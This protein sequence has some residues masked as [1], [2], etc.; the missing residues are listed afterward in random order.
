VD[1][2]GDYMVVQIEEIYTKGGRSYMVTDKVI[3]NDCDQEVPFI[4][5]EGIGTNGGLLFN[6]ENDR[7][8]R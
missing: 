3:S 1:F 5:I 7:V 4:I 6:I 2:E 8:I